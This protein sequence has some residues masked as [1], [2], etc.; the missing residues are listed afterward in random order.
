MNEQEKN[1]ESKQRAESLLDQLFI[2]GLSDGECRELWAGAVKDDQSLRRY[3]Q[4]VHLREGLRTLLAQVDPVGGNGFD[5]L[6]ADDPLSDLFGDSLEPTSQLAE[7]TDRRRK[8][9]FPLRRWHLAWATAASLAFVFGAIVTS[10]VVSR[11]ALQSQLAEKDA[12]WLSRSVA[13]TPSLPDAH[14]RELGKITGLS[15]AASVSGILSSMQVGQEL[16]YGEI[17]QLSEGFVRVRL[18]S[19]SEIIAEGPAEFSLVGE[20][21]VFVRIGRISATSE[22]GLVLQSPLVTAHCLDA[23]VA[24]IAEEDTSTSLYV[25]SGMINVYSTP[26]EDFVSSKLRVL[27][28]KEGMV[29][30]AMSDGGVSIM[31][32]AH[33]ASVITSWAE[34]E[35]RLTD[36][37]QMV[38]S[39]Q[40]M[41]YWPRAFRV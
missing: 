28:S 29:A 39:D 5:D 12:L 36:Y 41:A 10:L 11:S 21:T 7:R 25:Q 2:A 13:V 20:K 3:V 18:K 19:G 16:S 14:E 33:S 31:A 17:V 22:E 8:F 23:E 40:P 32:G 4:M 37:Q 35:S 9:S 26:Q 24:F 1:D 15:P 34:V 30:H 6:A 27:H 38:L